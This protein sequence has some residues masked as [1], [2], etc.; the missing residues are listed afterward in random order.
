MSNYKS[1]I[2]DT[3]V[4]ELLEKS[5]KGNY[6]KYLVSVRLEKIRQFSG[7]QIRFDFPVTALIGP[8]GSGKSTI[9]AAIACAY[10]SMNPS[11][12]FF[13][14]RLG[15]TGMDNWSVEYE[16]IDRSL[17]AGGTI[18]SNLQL[19]NNKWRKALDIVRDI[20]FVSVT[21]TVPAVESPFFVNKKRLKGSSTTDIS[22]EEVQN[23]DVVKTESERILGKSLAAFKLLNV[24]L[25]REK[26]RRRQIYMVDD[27]GKLK[28]KTERTKKQF[29]SKQSIYIGS[30]GENEY[31]EFNFG[32]GESAVI[33]MVADIESMPNYSLVLIEEIENGLHPIAVRRM[34]EYLIDA[35]KR[36]SI[37]VVFTTHS[38]YALAPLPSEA[39]WASANGTLQQ[40]KLSIEI[41]R[42]VS[43]RVDKKLAIFVE[44]EF[45]KAWVEAILREKLSEHLDEIGVY[46]VSGDGNAVRIHIGHTN[47]PAISFRSICFI[48][49]DSKQQED[50]DTGI[51]RLPGLMPELTVFNSVL[52][53]LENNI[54]L[55]TVACQRSLDRQILVGNEIKTV[56]RT[57]RDP[58]LLF[59]QIGL[60][61]GF[62]PE[63]IIRGAF[64]TMWIQ[65]NST[66]TERIV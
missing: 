17:N 65:E 48:D 4:R 5:K 57:N 12:F 23:I 31:S 6:S 3:L 44:D 20:K 38:D 15:D 28:T 9:L 25:T 60:R 62:V 22:T 30:D 21:R 37:Q 50:N 14:T 11:N 52:N 43:G 8:N 46:A 64:L 66:E 35:A 13:K 39:I 7:A 34:V 53:N 2:R 55:L 41:L 56:S 42:V 26:T 16:V 63:N 27:Q 1:E 19:K 32:S 49:G 33:R 45:A 54:A 58:H 36:K 24:T 59:S 29:R 61:I 51:F 18:R 40:G 10:E 47:N